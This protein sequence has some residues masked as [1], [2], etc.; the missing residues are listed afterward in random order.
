MKKQIAKILPLYTI[1]PLISAFTLNTLI[2]SGSMSICKNWHH[3]DFTSSLDRMVPVIPEWVYIYL[4]CYLFWIINYI[5]VARVH[6]DDPDGFYRYITTD[7]MS[8][9]VC[10]LF[11]F[12]LPTTNMRPAIVGSGLAEHLLRWVYSIDQPAN[13]FPS[14][15]CLVS[16]MCFIGIR[17]NKRVPRWYRIFSCIFALLVV[18]STQVTK[19]HYL[20]DAIGGI[21]LAEVL[22]AWNK[23]SNAY[24]YVKGFFERVNASLR[25]LSRKKKGGYA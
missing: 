15:H 18:V 22:Y 9:I 16:W 25:S 5:L 4:G 6:K 10:G 11:F 21:L 13:L 8:R 24:L 20:I 12:G 17:G 14:I 3:Y 2:Y 1:I 7:M 23:R 19:Q